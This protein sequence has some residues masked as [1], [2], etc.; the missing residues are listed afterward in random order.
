MSR[1]TDIQRSVED[2]RTAELITGAL[3]D[4]G[5]AKMH[6]IR[7]RFER[8]AEFFGGIRTVYGIVKAH[9]S[10]VA[11]DAAAAGKAALAP[12][13]AARDIYIA[14]TSNKRFYGTLNRDIV[15]AFVNTARTIGATSDFLVVGQT[16]VQYLREMAVQQK[17][18]RT[19][20]AD[21]T[22]NEEELRGMFA[23]IG[24]YQRVF[25]VYPKFVNPFR[26]DIAMVDITQTPDVSADSEAQVEYIFEPEIPRMLEF[27]ESQV[28]RA[29]FERV[30]LE[31]EL[32][33]SARRTMKM[34]EAR[35]RASDL[36]GS[37]ERSLQR[38]TATLAGIQ[39]METYI[40]YSFWR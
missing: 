17:I 15:H 28:R 39:L 33:R 6:D 13:K 32:A 34:R 24:G 25:L 5:S 40:G 30:L 1:I 35:D 4:L 9:A 26:Q 12:A 8:N 14:L 23:L 29:L 20:F 22:P 16:G 27:V 38:E 7:K 11:N 2:Y 37:F 21:D 31:T 36:R 19:Q 10:A 3:Q 18:A